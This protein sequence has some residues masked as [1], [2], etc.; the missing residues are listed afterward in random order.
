MQER[1]NLMQVQPI[2]FQ[3]N[4]PKGAARNFAQ[5]MNKLY[6]AAYRDMPEHSDII[7]VSAKIP[8]GKEI[9]GIATFDNG[10]FVNLSLPYEDACHRNAFC[11]SIIQKFNDVMTKGKWQKF[12]D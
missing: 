4:N 11:K 2:S 12:R 8:N 9:S 5:V 10:N 3:G 7:Q 1:G 6:K